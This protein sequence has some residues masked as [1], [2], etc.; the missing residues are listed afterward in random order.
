[1]IVRCELRID[2]FPGDCCGL[3]PAGGNL[4]EF[5]VPQS[6]EEG[7]TPS[8]L[9]TMRTPAGVPEGARAP[10]EVPFQRFAVRTG[11]QCGETPRSS[12]LPIKVV[13]LS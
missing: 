6:H 4:W 11:D 2:E 7:V 1:M 3:F 5:Q 13:T 10:C 8:D 9:I 12:R